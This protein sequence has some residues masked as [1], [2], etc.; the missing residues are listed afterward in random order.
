MSDVDA[1]MEVGAEV[2]PLQELARRTYC[3]ELAFAGEYSRLGLRFIRQCV[4]R[5][6][7]A[8]E[9]FVLRAIET[10]TMRLGD[11]VPDVVHD[12][13][14]RFVRFARWY[15]YS[16]L[17]RVGAYLSAPYGGRALVGT[18]VEVYGDEFL[19]MRLGAYVVFESRPVA[20]DVSSD[21][22]VESR[23]SETADSGSS[24]RSRFS[25]ATTTVMLAEGRVDQPVSSRTRAA[26]AFGIEPVW[27]VQDGANNEHI[28]VGWF[29]DAGSEYDGL[30]GVIWDYDWKFP[31]D[32]G[33][34]FDE[35]TNNR[36]FVYDVVILGS[37]QVADCNGWGYHYHHLARW[38]SSGNSKDVFS[39]NV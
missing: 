5:A 18:H 24:V 12:R 11:K 33:E 20:P 16:L 31:D 35:D 39:T 10:G 8:E 6:I 27:V 7:T 13:T 38:A 19:R 32:D 28:E 15:A 22:S 34:F 25:A 14:V 17:F 1:C 30:V 21:S 29:E 23:F 3:T 4:R 37:A 9:D 26:L 2:P 36:D